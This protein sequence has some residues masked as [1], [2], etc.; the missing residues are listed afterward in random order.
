MFMIFKL[1][2]QNLTMSCQIKTTYM[3]NIIIKQYLNTY[4]DSLHI[5]TPEFRYTFLICLRLR[6][7]TLAILSKQK[8]KKENK[9]NYELKRTAQGV[10]EVPMFELETISSMAIAFNPSIVCLLYHLLSFCL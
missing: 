4:R 8:K 1:L 10:Y 7:S 9:H 3:A 2:N 6:T 5:V